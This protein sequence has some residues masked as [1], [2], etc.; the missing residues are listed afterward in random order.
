MWRVG[1]PSPRAAR[2]RGVVV[3]PSNQVRDE[4]VDVLVRDAVEHGDEV[5]GT[6]QSVPDLGATICLRVDGLPHSSPAEPTQQG[7]IERGIE[8][9]RE[10][11]I[12][13]TGDLTV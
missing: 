1:G 4:A 8:R 9:A 12:Q 6:K 11:P 7:G 13:H 2:G 10:V 3:E 5:F